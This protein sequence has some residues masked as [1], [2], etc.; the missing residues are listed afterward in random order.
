MSVTVITPR[1]DRI[2]ESMKCCIVII[3]LARLRKG[4]FMVAAIKGIGSEFYSKLRCRRSQWPIVLSPPLCR[5]AMFGATSVTQYRAGG[6][7]KCSPP[8]PASQR[9]LTPDFSNSD[10]ALQ[11]HVIHKLSS[12]LEK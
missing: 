11:R 12:F 10:E 7:V 3:S 1:H 4:V 5:D 9:N 6:S 2:L 8:P